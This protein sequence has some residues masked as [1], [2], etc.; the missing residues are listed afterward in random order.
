MVALTGALR[1]GCIAMPHKPL[2]YIKRVRSRDGKIYEYF[3]TGAKKDG[4]PVLRPLPP[5]SDKMFGQIYSGML[6][7]RQ[8]RRNL[9]DIPTLNEVSRRYQ[10]DGVFTKRAES[11]QSTYLI[12]LNLL[13]E[14]MGQAHI[15]QIERRDVQALMDQMADRPGAA[16]MTLLVLRNLFK[17]AIKREWV[18]VDPTATVEPPEDG[19]HEHA[20]WPE[21][22]LHEALADPDPYVRLAVNLLFYTAQR[23][24]DVCRMRWDDIR[25]GMIYVRQQKTGKRVS[26][27]VHDKLQPVLDAT[28]RTALTIMIGTKGRPA[29]PDTVRIRLQ[30]W[31]KERGHQIVPHGLRKNAVN[32]LLEIGCSV[33]EVS[34]ISGQT[35][36]MVEHYAKERNG[37]RIGTAAILKWQGG[38]KAGNGKHG[39]TA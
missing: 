7:H 19:D 37:Q 23:I 33:A 6:A 13:S 14:K 4:K 9:H 29:R 20:P 32:T 31:A 16:A 27:P 8:A 39:K 28:P 30:A 2:A 15:D 18:K 35:L 36:D 21:P 38:T 3:V 24:G 10:L 34:S 26:F 12:Y 5:R 25:E 11:T 22:L 1:R 17:F